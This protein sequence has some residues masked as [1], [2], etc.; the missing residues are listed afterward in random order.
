MHSPPGAAC[1][2]PAVGQVA[3]ADPHA[4]AGACH[5]TAGA[6]DYSPSPDRHPL[7]TQSARRSFR[8]TRRARLAVTPPTDEPP[9]SGISILLVDDQPAN[10]L[11][12]EA[13]LE[14]PGRRLVR[15]SSV[16]QALALLASDDFVVVLLDL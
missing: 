1:P 5:A 16:E 3:G 13:I 8:P 2:L 15:A 11:G 4:A 9:V 12:L 14:V 6:V 7:P 10:L